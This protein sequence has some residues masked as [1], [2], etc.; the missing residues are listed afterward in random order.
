[1]RVRR[2]DW[3]FRGAHATPP[4]VRPGVC[5]VPGWRVYG[6]PAAA[7]GGRR[8][9]PGAR[10]RLPSWIPAA[11]RAAASGVRR[12]C[13]RGAWRARATAALHPEPD[14]HPVRRITEHPLIRRPLTLVHLVERLR[15]PPPQ[16][17][18]RDHR[19]R[20]PCVCRGRM[21]MSQRAIEEVRRWGHF[22]AAHSRAGCIPESRY[23]QAH[24]AGAGGKASAIMELTVATR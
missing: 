14:P 11:S 9:W 5:W 21:R 12:D 19:V 15:M 13:S 20:V 1:M 17:L 2:R 3:G 18:Q 23:D 22:R 4:V 7:G 16:Q 6:Y 24:L 10:S 8:P